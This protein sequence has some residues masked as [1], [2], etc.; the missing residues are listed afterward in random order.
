LSEL[1]GI[2]TALQEL[3]RMY[4]LNMEMLEQLDVIFK[5][6]IENDVP[7]PNSDKLVSLLSKNQALLQELYS[8]SPAI[9]TYQKLNRRKVTPFRTDED[10]TEPAKK[11]FLKPNLRFAGKPENSRQ[12]C[13]G[14]Y[15]DHR[16]FFRHQQSGI[17]L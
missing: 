5:W 13:L 15:A 12:I 10:E 2:V 1:S 11:S 17:N 14:D 8:S 6:I 9:L 3:E 7:I 4:Q 16:T